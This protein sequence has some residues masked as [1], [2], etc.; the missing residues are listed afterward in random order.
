MPNHVA[1][2]VLV[3][4]RAAGGRQEIGRER[5]EAVERQ[6]ARDVLDMRIE[7]AVLVDHDHR[8]ET[9]AGRRLGEISLHRAALAGIAHGSRR[10]ARIVGLH[11]GRLGA[12]D[13][14]SGNS[15][16]AAAVP[17][18]KARKPIEEDAPFERC[19]GVFVVEL[20]DAL[21][22]VRLPKIKQGDRDPQAIPASPGI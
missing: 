12:R 6:A 7:A 11:H 22:H 18:A 2:L 16:A 1:R 8:P 20:D 17:P 21:V 14:S 3:G 4:G 10:D 15:G 19:V 9:R 13:L 5:D